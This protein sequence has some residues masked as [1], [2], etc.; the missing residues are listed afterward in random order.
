M[1]V[2]PGP[3]NSGAVTTAAPQEGT[4]TRSHSPPAGRRQGRPAGAPETAPT[5]RLASAPGLPSRRCGA[6]RRALGAAQ[7]GRAPLAAVAGAGRPRLCREPPPSPARPG[8][9]STG[10]GGGGAATAGRAGHGRAGQGRAGPPR[11]PPPP[12]RRQ[13]DDRR[14][15]HQQQRGAHAVPLHVLG[16]LRAQL[17]R[18]GDLLL[19]LAPALPHPQA[20][21]LHRPGGQPH[22]EPP[23]EEAGKRRVGGAGG[24]AGGCAAPCAPAGTWASEYART[25]AVLPA[26][27]ASALVRM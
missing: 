7:P 20:G 6:Q 23:Q 8:P 24:A 26:A 1:E 21:A 4:A 2:P 22:P 12:R 27:R 10:G 5:A 15:Q 25:V 11:A 18:R 9:A 16:A 17:P 13:K 19:R 3:C 14:Q